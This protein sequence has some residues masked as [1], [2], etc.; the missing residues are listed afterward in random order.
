[1]VEGPL[2]QLPFTADAVHGL[3]LERPVAVAAA[4]GVDWGEAVV[5]QQPRQPPQLNAASNAT[6]VP[7]GKPPITPRMAS[8]PLGTFRFASTSPSASITAT[9][10][11]LRCTSIP[12]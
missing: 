9:W 11:R 10:E 2:G 3:Q 8:A 7:G 12:T 1:V 5:L 6:G 4:D